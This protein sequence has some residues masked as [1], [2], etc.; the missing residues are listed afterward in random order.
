MVLIGIKGGGKEGMRKEKCPRALTCL[1]GKV[2]DELNCKLSAM[3]SLYNN[4]DS[5]GTLS[6]PKMNYGHDMLLFKKA[7]CT[8]YY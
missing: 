3:A 4:R 6:Y 7:K 5:N 1:F 2:R 8:T